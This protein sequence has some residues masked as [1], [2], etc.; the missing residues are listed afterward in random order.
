MSLRIFRPRR[1]LLPGRDFRLPAPGLPAEGLRAADER[2]GS[3]PRMDP[4]CGRQVLRREAASVLKP[5]RRTAAR[6]FTTLKGLSVFMP[7]VTA[8]TSRVPSASRTSTS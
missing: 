6:Y 1:F 8:W 2:Q 3:L 4:V 7:W 5:G